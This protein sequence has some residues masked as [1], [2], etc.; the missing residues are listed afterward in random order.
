MRGS[1]LDLVRGRLFFPV[2]T[3]TPPGSQAGETWILDAQAWFKTSLAATLRF[4]TTADIGIPGGVAP[5]NAQGLID[6]AFLP[7]SVSASGRAIGE[8]YDWAGDPLATPSGVLVCDGNQYLRAEFPALF[9]V[10]GTRW[11]RTASDAYFRVPNLTDRTT[12][13]AV[14]GGAAAAGTVHKVNA[15]TRGTGYAPGAYACTFSGGTFSVPATG[16]LTVNAD[17]GIDSVAIIL[18]GTYTSIGSPIAGSP[19]NCAIQI[20]SSGLNGGSGFTYEIMARPTAPL[21]WTVR[22]TNRG[23]GYTTASVVL[24]G[25]LVGGTAIAVLGAGGTVQ[26]ILVT[27]P[28]TGDPTTGTVVISGN[29]AL[30]TASAVLLNVPVVS[31][32]YVGEAQHVQNAEEVGN[33]THLLTGI[34][35]AGTDSRINASTV[36]GTFASTQANV[37]GNPMPIRSPGL[38]L[39]KL[40]RAQ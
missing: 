38:G 36:L 25:G 8:V 10:I 31:G 15:K 12:Y 22:M 19:S 35:A 7:A 4:L 39:I 5:L 18:G 1:L 13:G 26:E 24:G 34:G 3:N 28:G 21:T 23:S 6:S 30:A 40:I 2:R 16:T 20:S 17:G 32:D 37:G 9:A 29:G 14:A 27:N 33:H 11:G